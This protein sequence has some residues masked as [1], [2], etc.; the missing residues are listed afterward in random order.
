MKRRGNGHTF[1]AVVQ[2]IRKD[3]E[4]WERAFATTQ[5]RMEGDELARFN[6][7][8]DTFA[9]VPHDDTGD[10]RHGDWEFGVVGRW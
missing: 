9:L 8:A 1:M 7:F 5:Y 10:E 2:E 4:H 3:I 6:R